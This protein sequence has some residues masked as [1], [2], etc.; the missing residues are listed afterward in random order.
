[1]SRKSPVKLKKHQKLHYI[2]ILSVY[3]HNYL[4][5]DTFRS[6]LGHPW[7]MYINICI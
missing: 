7:G 3:C 6:F 2:E 5:S 1:M 4:H